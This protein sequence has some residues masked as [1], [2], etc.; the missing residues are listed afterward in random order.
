VNPGNADGLRR[1]HEADNVDNLVLATKD[2][3]DKDP[4]S[5][6]GKSTNPARGVHKAAVQGNG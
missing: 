5:V 2:A 3:L 4:A 1:A 6:A